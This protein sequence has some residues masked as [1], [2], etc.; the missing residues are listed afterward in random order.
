MKKSSY[1]FIALAV[2]AGAFGAI[3]LS[4]W[5]SRRADISSLA[6][7][8]SRTPVSFADDPSIS[9]PR[10]FSDTASK[11]L[12]SVVSVD[13]LQA[14]T[15]F[16]TDQ[17][18]IR[19]AATG[20]GVILTSTGVIV[21][22]NHVVSG[23]AEVR[24]RLSDKR[25]F[26]AKVIGTDKRADLAVLKIDGTNLTPIQMG[27]SDKMRPG[28]WVMAVGNPLDFAETVSVGVVSNTSRTLPTQNGGVLVHAI[29]TDA[30][31]NP[32]NSGGA[33]TD[34]QGRLIGI[35][36]AISSPTGSSIGIGFAIPVNR[37]RQ[38]VHDILKYGHSMEGVLGLIPKPGWDGLL[39]DPQARQELASASGADSVPQKG[40]VIPYPDN[41]NGYGLVGG[42]P[43]AA[44]GLR[45]LDIILSIDG[46][47]ITDNLSFMAALADKRA[48]QTVQVQYWSKG[49]TKTI[50]IVLAQEGTDS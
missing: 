3:Q 10:D 33:L 2:F 22:N 19:K 21:T 9:G 17:T 48:G 43:A 49:Q 40:L 46:T 16:W 12:P 13:N 8:I 4:S 41:F 50:G 7:S 25:V 45:P 6:G 5:L 47:P 26:M 42:Y 39:S 30:A 1:L 36:S 37:V 24:V 31:I 14:Q 44:A 34:E 23:A 35:N 11:V 27:D 32:G 20:S 15:N 18:S 29:Q 38:T 28:Q